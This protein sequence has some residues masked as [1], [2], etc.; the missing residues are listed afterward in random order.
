MSSA[1]GRTTVTPVWTSS[2]MSTVQWPTVTPATSLMR[3]SAPLGR[4]PMRGMKR[5]AILF[6]SL[7]KKKVCIKP[8]KACGKG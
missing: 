8:K 5:F 6:E 3:S 1:L 7:L 4:V 2:P